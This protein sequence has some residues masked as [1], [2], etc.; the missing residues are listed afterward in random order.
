[1]KGGWEGRNQTGDD[2]R[3]AWR[4]GDM[5]GRETGEGEPGELSREL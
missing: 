5:A 4:A 2:I 1:M 3:V